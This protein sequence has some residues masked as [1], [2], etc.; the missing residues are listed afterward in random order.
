MA[1]QFTF[2]Q[3][4][5]ERIKRH[6]T[7]K[8]KFRLM[9]KMILPMGHKSR[10]YIT[11]LTEESCSVAVPYNKRN[12]N[13]FKSTFWAVQAM[14]AEMS[15]GALLIM[16]THN[17]SE[18]IAMLV[19][20]MDGK[21]VKKAVNV[22]TFVCNDGLKIKKAIEET[23]ETRE[24]RLIE[25]KMTGKDEKGNDISHFTFTWSVKARNKK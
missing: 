1:D 20:N 24:P 16:Y 10:M 9:L 4:S 21:F 17:Q 25:C 13:P 3:D 22:T 7:N 14:A 2:D 5:I 8:F 18:S 19:M 6:I 15:S 23:I 12:S 11:S